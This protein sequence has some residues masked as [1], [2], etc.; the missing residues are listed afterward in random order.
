MTG[1]GDDAQWRLSVT[2][3]G[4]PVDPQ[5]HFKVPCGDG[6]LTILELTRVVQERCQ[7]MLPDHSIVV[8][9]LYDS[10][11]CI[12][13]PEDLAYEVLDNKGIVK[14]CMPEPRGRGKQG[15]WA[16]KVM[17]PGEATKVAAS[18]PG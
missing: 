1:G 16:V 13:F 4:F 7:R 12:L 18:R 9:R 5:L 14:A 10:E 8:E 11:G 6:S 3:E 15:E 17:R 2:T